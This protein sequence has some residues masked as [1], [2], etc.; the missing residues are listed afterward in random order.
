MYGQMVLQLEP[1]E[2]YTVQVGSY[3]DASAGQAKINELAQLGYRVC[4]SQGPPYCLWLGCFGKAPQV[5]DLPQS[6]QESAVM[7]LYRNW[8]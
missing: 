2:Y 8:C 6:I 4:V 5:K 3:Q 1:V 7:C